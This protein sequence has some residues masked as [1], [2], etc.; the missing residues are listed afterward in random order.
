MG[1]D[2]LIEKPM[3]LTLSEAR[4]LLGLA[5][6]RDL[7]FLISCP[8][9]YAPHATLAPGSQLRRTDCMQQI[10]LRGII[11]D[12]SRSLPPL[13][14]ASQ[15]FEEE[16]REIAEIWHRR[17]L[18]EFGHFDLAA[19][20]DVYDLLIADHPMMGDMNRSG[21]LADLK[22]LV[23]TAPPEEARIGRAWI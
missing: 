11:W 1:K 5:V 20:A 13:V 18:D 12:H 14:A 8:L 23:S 19:L 7:Q 21:A 17:S 6:E 3:S 9:H 22:P 2:V 16:H 15:R 4:D 10:C